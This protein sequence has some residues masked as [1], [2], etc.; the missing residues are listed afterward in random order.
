MYRIITEKANEL[1]DGR[2]NKYISDIIG[3]NNCH[4]TSILTG[5]RTCSKIVAMVLINLKTNIPIGTKK[6]EDE[7]KKYF[8]EVK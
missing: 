7:L 6:M 1:K 4:I 2:T 5:N 8:H 3:M